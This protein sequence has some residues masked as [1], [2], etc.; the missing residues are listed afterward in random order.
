VVGVYNAHTHRNKRTSAMDAPGVPFIE[1]GAVKEYPG[2]FGLVRVHEGGYA[3]NFYKTHSDPSRAWSER[4]RGEYLGLYP[5]Y[6][7]GSM[8]DRNFVVEADF[9]GLSPEP[10]PAPT[11]PPPS[12]PHP[13]PATGL[14]ATTT[15]AVAASA[16]ALAAH[17]V[18]DRTDG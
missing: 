3:V 7:L 9:S 16:A 1:L 5:Y 14:G 6:T 12:H 13:L 2:G 18:R 11:A 8:A 4:S 17:A 10:A 15:A